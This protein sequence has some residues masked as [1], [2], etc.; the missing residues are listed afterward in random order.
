MNHRASLRVQLTT[1]FTIFTFLFATMTATGAP[2]RPV[3]SKPVPASKPADKPA[4]STPGLNAFVQGLASDGSVF[5]G[6]LNITSF[7]AVGGK[8]NAVGTLALNLAGQTVTQAV[9]IPV[10]SID[11]SCSI[12]NLVL[13]PLNL[14]LLGLNISLNQVVLII[15][16]TQGAGNLLGN[17][18]CDVANL[19]N[20]GGNLSTLLNDLVTALNNLI[21]GL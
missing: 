21:A 20:P 18:L 13:G 8:L 3:S 10:A 16:A 12:L 2:T 15:T 6:L 11:P 5:N 1:M 19:L 14:T 7:Q 4:K 9:S 17:L